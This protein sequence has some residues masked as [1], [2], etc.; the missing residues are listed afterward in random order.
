MSEERMKILEMLSEG[1]LNAEEAARLL[2]AL[3]GSEDRQE[4]T[5]KRSR[6][7]LGLDGLDGLEDEIRDGLEDARRALEEAVPEVERALGEAMPEI[8]RAVKVAVG[9][10]PNVGRIV[11]DA[12]RSVSDEAPRQRRRR[13]SRG[14]RSEAERHVSE[15]L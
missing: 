5:K 15:T 9:S 3:D 8:G 12:L 6:S 7:G 10:I 2:D 11:K 14:G 4:N 13:R 1:K